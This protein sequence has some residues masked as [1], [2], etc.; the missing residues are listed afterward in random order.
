M[1][2]PEVIAQKGRNGRNAKKQKM[3]EHI[4]QK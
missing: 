3:W 1:K 2:Y 4:G